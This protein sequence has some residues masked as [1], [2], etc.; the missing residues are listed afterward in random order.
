MRQYYSS[1]H[2]R[3]GFSHFRDSTDLLLEKLSG[4]QRKQW[5]KSGGVREE[6]V[7]KRFL[8]LQ[9]DGTELYEG[10]IIPPQKTSTS[11]GRNPGP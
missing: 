7:L 8:R 4:W 10:T 5:Q 6:A 9:K 11:Q 3:R 1:Q 2:G